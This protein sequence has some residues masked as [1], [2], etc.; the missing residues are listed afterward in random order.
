MALFTR[1]A[2]TPP[3][4]KSAKTF[5]FYDLPFSKPLEVLLDHS[6][7]P[8]K[9][10]HEFHELLERAGTVKVDEYNF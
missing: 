4:A 1:T 6:F 9:G 3:F 2:K 10:K 7:L 8:E 5:L